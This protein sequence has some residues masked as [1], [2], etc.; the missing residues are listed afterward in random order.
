MKRVFIIFLMFVLMIIACGCRAANVGTSASA[1]PD[2]SSAPLL[3]SGTNPLPTTTVKRVPY[4]QLI[5][6]TFQS[7]YTTEELCTKADAVVRARIT[8]LSFYVNDSLPILNPMIYTT[9]TVEILQTYMGEISGT[10]TF[11]GIGGY[12]DCFLDEQLKLIEEYGLGGITIID[13]MEYPEFNKE[14]MFILSKNDGTWNFMTLDQYM[15]EIDE[16]EVVT[17][18]TIPSYKSILDYLSNNAE[19][20]INTN[21]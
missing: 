15:F 4:S 16:D 10:I 6:D 11:D 9:Y 7:R 13:G 8:N 12:P 5:I 18:P 21:D 14:Y 1:A 19:N 2:A 20:S 3:S 17:D